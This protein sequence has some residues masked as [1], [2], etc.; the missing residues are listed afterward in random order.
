MRRIFKYSLRLGAG[1]QPVEMP[2]GAN[3]VHIHEQNNQACLWAEVDPDAEPVLRVFSVYETGE[4]ID[5]DRW[6]YVGTV[7][8][9]WA[10]WHV[11]EVAA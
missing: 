7:H 8:L 3:V 10:V 1:P 9:D 5:D 11:Y 6:R 4:S 2:A